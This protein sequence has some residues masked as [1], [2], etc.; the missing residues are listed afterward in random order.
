MKIF[1]NG[2]SRKIAVAAVLF[3]MVALSPSARANATYLSNTG[4]FA[5]PES[6]FEQTFTLSSTSTIEVQTW[7]FGGGTNAAGQLILPGGFDSLVALF[8]GTATNASILTDGSGNPIA[9]AQNFF[10]PY[11]FALSGCPPAGTVTVGAVTGVCGDNTL[12]ATLSAGTYT[13]L[14]TDANFVALAVNPGISSPFDLTDTT[15]NLY[16]TG[17]GSYNDLSAGVFQTC[18]SSTD[19]NTDNGGFAVDIVDQSGATISPT[20]EPG[21]LALYVSGLALMGFLI[22]KR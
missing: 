7:G 12:M 18:A 6:A 17:N 22:R 9:D 10:N 11:P 4:T 16:G 19:C 13:L 20:P 14:L 3:A 15:S 21:T 2:I 8:S 5:T 1:V